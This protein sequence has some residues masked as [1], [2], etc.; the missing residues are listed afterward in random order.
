M[1]NRLNGK[2]GDG[3]FTGRVQTDLAVGHE[4]TFPDALLEFGQLHVR[5]C[6]CNGWSDF[7]VLVVNV[8]LIEPRGEVAQ[9]V[10]GN[11]LLGVAPCRE[12]TYGDRGLSVGEVWLVV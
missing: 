7:H 3:N 6:D 5:T 2:L 9:R 1:P 4:T 12:R 10:H 11:D 8:V